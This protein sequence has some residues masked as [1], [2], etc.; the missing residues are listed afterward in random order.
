MPKY[1]PAS[2]KK[3]QHPKPAKPQYA[4]HHWVF[5]AYGQRIKMA[6]VDE[7]KQLDSK[8]I[9]RVQSIV[10]SIL[11]QSQALDSTTMVALNEL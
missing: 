3:L 2:L 11:Y 8:G 1:I 7:S 9:R 10:G 4:P 6:T 5:P